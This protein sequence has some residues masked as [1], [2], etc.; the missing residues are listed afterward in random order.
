ML[1]IIATASAATVEW[2]KLETREHHIDATEKA[3]VCAVA[4]PCD[5]FVCFQSSFYSFLYTGA[6]KVS[7]LAGQPQGGFQRVAC[8]PRKGLRRQAGGGIAVIFCIESLERSCDKAKLSCGFSFAKALEARYQ[9]D[10][11]C[12]VLSRSMSTDWR[13]G[14]ITSTSSRNT[15]R[16]R[17]LTGYVTLLSLIKQR[18]LFAVAKLAAFSR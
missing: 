1:C 16:R 17:L 8:T 13:S 6:D 2:S 14:W 10:R 4:R 11:S 12:A 3:K 9:S 15:T 5:P 18:R 7:T